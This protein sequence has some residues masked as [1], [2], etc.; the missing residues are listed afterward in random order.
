MNV[1]WSAQY[2]LNFYENSIA[3]TAISLN[4]HDLSGPNRSPSINVLC[5]FTLYQ[6]Q[7]HNDDHNSQRIEPECCR[8]PK[9]VYLDE[10]CELNTRLFTT[11]FPL[12]K[13]NVHI[14]ILASR[15]HIF[16]LYLN[17]ADAV[18]FC[19]F[20]AENGE[21]FQFHSNCLIYPVVELIRRN[22]NGKFRTCA[23]NSRISPL[24]P[25]HAADVTSS[26]YEVIMKLNK[27]VYIAYH[28]HKLLSIDSK[29]WQWITIIHLKSDYCNFYE[30]RKCLF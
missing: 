11:D 24:H 20:N 29:D 12:S 2:D 16:R 21:M 4:I 18:T 1:G 13:D 30:M 9:S 19:H 15:F 3:L 25:I 10:T 23:W 6:I 22:F 28:S 5:T 14:C 27:N 8:Y 17:L 7:Q 26:S